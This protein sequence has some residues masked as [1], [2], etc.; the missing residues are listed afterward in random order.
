MANEI[1]VSANIEEYRKLITE[2]I[3]KQIVILGPDIAVMKARNVSGLKV[4]NDGTVSSMEG[5]PHETLRR[6]V[7]EYVDLSGL[8]VKKTMEPLLTKYPS[9]KV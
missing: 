1:R 2:V 4:E 8:I 9:I 3:Q 5:N 7:D 6:L